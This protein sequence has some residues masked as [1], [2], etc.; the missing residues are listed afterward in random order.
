M[1]QSVKTP[2]TKPAELSAIPRAHMVVRKKQL[3][4][5]VL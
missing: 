5:A 4:Q 2:A 3:L 1:T